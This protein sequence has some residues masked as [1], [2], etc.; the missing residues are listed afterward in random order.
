MSL[1]EG[2]NVNLEETAAD[3]N[4]N[5]IAVA[6]NQSVRP[7]YKEQLA[8]DAHRRT[9]GLPGENSCSK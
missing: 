4:Q 6:R 2:L 1:D 9:F 7:I 8:A 5:H 3:G